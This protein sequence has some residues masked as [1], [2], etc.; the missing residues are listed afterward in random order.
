MQWPPG[1]P[2]PIARDQDGVN[3][4]GPVPMTFGYGPNTFPHSAAHV[5]NT[6]L[7][8]SRSE[9]EPINKMHTSAA[10]HNSPSTSEGVTKSYHSMA[11]STCFTHV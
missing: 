11:K 4:V 5:L 2:S 9:G 8:P 6:N 3:T 1:T 10:N 7:S